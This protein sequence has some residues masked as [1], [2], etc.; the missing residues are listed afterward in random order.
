MHQVKNLRGVQWSLPGA[1]PSQPTPAVPV[2]ESQPLA[3]RAE[4]SPM[5]IS[6]LLGLRMP[7]AVATFAVPDRPSYALHHDIVRLC[8][9]GV[10][11]DARSS[12]GGAATSA[13]L[14]VGSV[15]ADAVHGTTHLPIVFPLQPGAPVDSQ[16][17]PSQSQPWL[18]VSVQVTPMTHEDGD[19]PAA[20]AT[21]VTAQMAA[22]GV[23]LR[24]PC[25]WTVT[26]HLGLLLASPSTTTPQPV[27]T[28]LQPPSRDVFTLRATAASVVVILPAGCSG[29]SHTAT[30]QSHASPTGAAH[31]WYALSG[32]G[33][34]V[35]GVQLVVG[36]EHS[37]V[38]AVVSDVAAF[39]ST[40]RPQPQPLP[41]A[42]APKSGVVSPSLASR[43]GL[44]VGHGGMAVGSA[45]ASAHLFSS[46][47]QAYAHGFVRE[48][49]TIMSDVSARV[50]QEGVRTSSGGTRVETCVSL[51]ALRVQATVTQCAILAAA[52]Q[53]ITEW[54]A[55]AQ[56]V[57]SMAQPPPQAP[58]PSH[59]PA[60]PA[61][62]VRIA[63]PYVRV[64][65]GGSSRFRV[66]SIDP[67][68]DVAMSDVA[69]LAAEDRRQ[70]F[71][72]LL[73][74]RIVGV[75]V[76]SAS[77]CSAA[78]VVG[79]TGGA[80]DVVV[81]DGGMSVR[82]G[83]L[84][85]LGQPEWP[86]C[87]ALFPDS[88]RVP[89]HFVL[90]ATQEHNGGDGGD[91]SAVAA[92]STSS[93][94]PFALWTAQPAS[95]VQS[96]DSSQPLLAHSLELAPLAV[97]LD[98]GLAVSCV[99]FFA[100]W[101]LLF[102][103]VVR[104]RHDVPAPP[105]VVVPTEPSTV[106][107]LKFVLS[108]AQVSVAAGDGPA[109]VLG[110]DSVFACLYPPLGPRGD[111]PTGSPTDA[112]ATTSTLETSVSGLRLACPAHYP[113]PVRPPPLAHATAESDWVG[114][115]G[116]T[117]AAMEHLRLGVP[118][119]HP[120]SVLADLAAAQVTV[121]STPLHSSVLVDARRLHMS[122]GT[123]KL[124][125]AARIAADWRLHALES[126]QRTTDE[127]VAL[128]ASAGLQD[129]LSPTPPQAGV[130]NTEF[131]APAPSE[132]G[133]EQ[134][135]DFGKLSRHAVVG[136]TQVPSA[137]QLLI[138]SMACALRHP[139]SSHGAHATRHASAG[140]SDW[141][142]TVRWRYARPRC[143]VSLSAGD[144]PLVL[145]VAEVCPDR[146]VSRLVDAARRERAGPG[147]GAD[148]GSTDRDSA[149]RRNDK[150]VVHL[151]RVLQCE[152]RRWDPVV[153]APHVVARFTVPV[154]LWGPSPDGT[155]LVP[156]LTHDR[157]AAARLFHVDWVES[158]AQAAALWEVVWILP[159]SAR[160]ATDSSDRRGGQCDRQ[161][162]LAISHSLVSCLRVTSCYSA[163]HTPSTQLRVT[164][165]EADLGLPLS[166]TP[167]PGRGEDVVRVLLRDTTLGLRTW[168]DVSGEGHDEG[169]HGAG[170]AESK[171]QDVSANPDQPN[172]RV[173]PPPPSQVIR[174][175]T[176]VAVA[177]AC[178]RDIAR[179]N[180]L[181]EAHIDCVVTQLG[182]NAATATA[183]SAD[184]DGGAG[185]VTRVRLRSSPIV[186]NV[187]EPAVLAFARTLVQ[188]SHQVPLITH[189]ASHGTLEPALGGDGMVHSQLGAETAWHSI[190]RSAGA[191]AWRRGRISVASAVSVASA[192]HEAGGDASTR[193]AA[194]E[195]SQHA[196]ISQG[197]DDGEAAVLR[198]VVVNACGRG[199]WLGQHATGEAVPLAPGSRTGY[200]WDSTLVDVGLRTRRPGPAKPRLLRLALASTTLRGG[201]DG[202][203]ESTAGRDG[204]GIT[205]SG[206]VIGE[207]LAWCRPVNVDTAGS[208]TVDVLG[209]T[210]SG[211]EARAQLHLTI[212]NEAGQRVITIHGSHS[213]WSYCRGVRLGMRVLR[214]STTRPPPPPRIAEPGLFWTA[215]SY[216]TGSDSALKLSL[217]SKRAAA[218][219]AQSAVRP[220]PLV[221][222]VLPTATLELPPV[223]S[224]AD[225]EEASAGKA[226]PVPAAAAAS[227]PGCAVHAL[228]GQVEDDPLVMQ[229]RVES[230]GQ[231]DMPWSAPVPL[232]AEAHTAS[233]ASRRGVWLLELPS[234]P[235]SKPGTADRT[236]VDSSPA[237]MTPESVSHATAMRAP[238]HHVLVVI[239]HA[240]TVRTCS[241]CTVPRFLPLPDCFLMCGHVDRTKQ[242]YHHRRE[243]TS[244]EAGGCKSACGQ[245]Q[246]WKTQRTSPSRLLFGGAIRAPILMTQ[247]CVCV[248]VVCVL[249][250][251][252]SP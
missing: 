129:A 170:A 31:A 245:P 239:G 185:V 12:D 48:E 195:P 47:T 16:S 52:I 120:R 32:V 58:P 173:L 147:M 75:D 108:G 196:G 55:P 192:G 104:P 9:A 18:S 141:G 74:L 109:V 205:A 107:S 98:A 191:S 42:A 232:I 66:A 38:A 78:L 62:V 153:D 227:E 186:L 49:H 54:P 212:V 174:A 176:R 4:P 152:L 242:G 106:S 15:V 197:I 162:H 92:A 229:L 14:S 30:S 43:Q 194:V 29:G 59:S 101:Q 243:A 250:A 45:N 114:L 2:N 148:S 171:G 117:P 169:V 164:M 80:G 199:V 189:V 121:T 113:C 203:V 216:L 73:D 83:H 244:T 79:A 67:R 5:E 35:G 20:S 63:V 124:M 125:R 110:V 167:S 3:L 22:L 6:W 234:A 160:P 130:S 251:L 145:P 100:L 19:T 207:P 156:L 213:F 97:Y 7:A 89:R 231:T 65:A 247:M 93:A 211:S 178:L 94:P 135:D 139:S 144:G 26:E 44:G 143:V 249:G 136:K 122:L 137:G 10:R 223:L 235:T 111:A 150:P 133:L 210:G 177:V 36:P 53:H 237:P 21:E 233:G 179:V 155:T 95:R 128:L 161:S 158:S 146:D 126:Y 70:P 116:H 224:A 202:G 84:A 184:G 72:P 82:V 198:F 163:T 225:R 103:A 33:V 209:N 27:T 193:G 142:V 123:S 206:E 60:T 168:A 246:L 228:L 221:Q 214:L 240:T 140:D 112:R 39:T 37:Q 248:C 190:A 17:T 238:A 77:G 87:V 241:S 219:A 1:S 88:V 13:S 188:F 76:V 138:S 28:E 34:R 25:V 105:A 23:M 175:G 119:I 201:V 132:G 8:I 166:A 51:D 56:D 204:G 159:E 217:E 252:L 236:G 61:S 172:G 11:L 151:P 215:A 165:D 200:S 134:G 90:A 96:G 182:S 230:G 86:T 208:V 64:Q 218:L 46:L 68:H 220:R 181:D 131:T 180:V 183:S 102:T 69:A 40:F 50:S 85:M 127:V 71:V 24:L 222:G 149:R 118:V 91:A 57:S 226:P 81:C 115:D 41:A 154:D 157:A 99:E 187:Y